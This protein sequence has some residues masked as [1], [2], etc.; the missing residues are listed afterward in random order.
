MKSYWGS[1]GAFETREMLLKLYEWERGLPENW[2]GSPEN[3][4]ICQ[5]PHL[6]EVNTMLL[7]LKLVS[8]T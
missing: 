7:V 3:S 2:A 1:E 5:G 6:F 8:E 4:K